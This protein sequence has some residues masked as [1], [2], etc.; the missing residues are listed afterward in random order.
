MIEIRQL[1]TNRQSL[2]NLQ[3]ELNDISAITVE[4][5]FIKTEKAVKFENKLF[6][7]LELMTWD[8][9]YSLFVEPDEL[10]TAFLKAARALCYILWI[11][12][13]ES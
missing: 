2:E 9:I 8:Q 13:P 3:K 7:Y 12:N 5:T 6:E 4:K 11:F 1:K 10:P